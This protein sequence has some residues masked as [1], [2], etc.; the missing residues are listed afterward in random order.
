MP[1]PQLGG[2]FAPKATF[3]GGDQAQS[4]AIHAQ[5]STMPIDIDPECSFKPLINRNI[6]DFGRMH[7]ILARQLAANKEAR[8]FQQVK[9]QQFAST[10][11]LTIIPLFS[12]TFSS[13]NQGTD[14]V[15]VFATH[16]SISEAAPTN[17]CRY[18]S[19]GP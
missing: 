3:G 2:Q 7:A 9:F 13:D 8:K 6:P 4:A 19:H 17:A 10:L 5:S 15:L 14:T 12:L 11:M 16:C 18:C 1:N